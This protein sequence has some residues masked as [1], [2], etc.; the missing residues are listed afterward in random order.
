MK[1]SFSCAIIAGGSGSRFGGSVKSKLIV[2]GQTIMS[3]ILSIVDDIFE[4]KI[5]VTNTPGDFSGYSSCK[6]VSDI[7]RK[8]GPL[9]GIHS[10]LK[11]SG[12][13]FVFA[14]AGDMP[15]LNKELILSQINEFSPGK[16][17]ALV[18]R[19]NGLI[20]PLHAI[21]NKAILGKIEDFLSDNQNRSVRDL[22]ALIRTGY[23]ELPESDDYKKAFI[24]IN[25]PSDL[26]HLD[27]GSFSKEHY[28]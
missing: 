15:F 13:E 8:S 5:I 7:Y 1:G 16:Y 11:S 26:D 27:L 17:D 24:N 18:P 9:A 10:A 14:F 23:L 20:E 19:M 12:A 6:I 21:Y 3:R 22:L 25:R 4:E 2:Q 28:S